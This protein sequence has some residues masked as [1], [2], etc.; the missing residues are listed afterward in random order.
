MM[1]FTLCGAQVIELGYARRVLDALGCG[2]YRTIKGGTDDLVVHRR[3]NEDDCVFYRKESMRTNESYLG[4][5]AVD[6]GFYTGH[7]DHNG[8][9]SARYNHSAYELVDYT[10]LLGLICRA[11]FPDWR[12]T[13]SPYIG[14]GRTQ[15][16]YAEEYEKKLDG[17][18][19]GG[20]IKFEL[21]K[22]ASEA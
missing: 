21:P 5:L 19:V 20:R 2:G 8:E 15:R 10:S 22:R 16:H 13:A 11:L 12:P 9:Y 17:V 1:K 3:L 14:H 18:E 4:N 6:E 7:I